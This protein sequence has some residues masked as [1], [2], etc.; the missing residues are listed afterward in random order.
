MTM[1][2]N[3]SVLQSPTPWSSWQK[4]ASP[5]DQSIAERKLDSWLVKPTDGLFACMNRRVSVPI[6]RRLIKFSITPNMV[7]MFTLLVSFA[8]GVFFAGGRYWSILFGAILSVWASILD[9]CDGE[10]ARLKL[11]SSDFGCWLETICD[12]LYYLFIFGG[13][14]LGLARSRGTNAYLMWGALLGFGAITSFL[15]VGYMR[16][17]FAGSHPEKFLSIWQKKAETRQ[18]NPLLFLGRQTEF[19]IRRC[20]LPYAFLVFAVLNIT[21]FAFLGAAVGANVVWIIALYSCIALS[22][23]Q[24][25]FT[26]SPQNVLASAESGDGRPRPSSAGESPAPTLA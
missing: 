15:T 9:G 2:L 17:R 7:T 21:R 14:S 11:Q 24:R 6:S 3:A 8:S 20:F 18:S 26:S 13:M 22:G 5:E 4:I 25:P 16:Q 1:T 19:I 23:K 10:V 12:Y